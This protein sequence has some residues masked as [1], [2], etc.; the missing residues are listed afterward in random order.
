MKTINSLKTFL[1]YLTVIA[2]L[3]ACQ[4]VNNQPD[5]PLLA[6]SA[7]NISKEALVK[8][9]Q[10][11]V[12]KLSEVLVSDSTFVIRV[13]NKHP[14]ESKHIA[15]YRLRWFIDNYPFT[16]SIIVLADQLP[17]DT[18]WGL[19]L[20]R[21]SNKIRVFQ[22][23]DRLLPPALENLNQAYL[24]C[25]DKKLQAGNIYLTD[26]LYGEKTDA[27]FTHIA[28]FMGRDQKYPGVVKGRDYFSGRYKT[29]TRLYLRDSRASVGSRTLNTTYTEDFYIRNTGNEP[30]E[31]YKVSKSWGSSSCRVSVPDEP[32]K[33]GEEARIRIKYQPDETGS[34]RYKIT[35]YSN[36]PDSP[37]ELIISG[38]AKR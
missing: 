21:L 7:F 29:N 6:V 12:K 15:L 28:N 24:F 31:I 25:L 2:G 34:F 5:K 10:G 36:T 33:P 22:I 32:V 37:H 16:D 4:T 9:K 30:L 8:D 13:T 18:G 23:E 1:F 17:A 27:Y 20:K 26:S 14:E 19:A 3:F 38:T 11:V 35:I